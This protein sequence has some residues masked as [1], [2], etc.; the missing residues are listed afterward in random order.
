M[1]LRTVWDDRFFSQAVLT[2]SSEVTTMPARNVQDKLRRRAFRTQ[3]L[4]GQYL[5][6]DLGARTDG[7]LRPPA[8]ALV[9]VDHNLTMNAQITVQHAATPDFSEL[10]FNQTYPAWGDIIGYGE[11]RYDLLGFGGYVPAADLPFY[12]PRPIRVIYLDQDAAG[13][14]IEPQPLQHYWKFGFS[15]PDNPAGYLQ[16]GRI[17]PSYYDEYRYLTYPR[18][19]GGEDHSSI[20]E[21]AGG[22]EWC[23]R[24]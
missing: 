22:Q 7:Y 8:N 12:A 11:Y 2:P 5:L 18:D 19:L 10:L 9:L 14:S 21:S 6:A 23:D 24:R 20:E 13:Q 15:D 4:A 16:F 17:L 3:G 1:H